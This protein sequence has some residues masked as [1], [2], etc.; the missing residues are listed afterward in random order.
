MT[1]D[2]FEQW[3]QNAADKARG[4]GKDPSDHTTGAAIKNKTHIIDFL[5]GGKAKFTL[6]SMKTGRSISY[7]TKQMPHYTAIFTSDK[8]IYCGAITKVLGDQI[9]FKP[10]EQYNTLAG[11]A[12]AWFC[13]H[14]T[15]YDRIQIWHHGECSMC[16]RALTDPK[17]IERGIGPV[18][19]EV[20]SRGELPF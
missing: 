8:N 3:E 5:F 2:S 10:T 20:L 7:H 1:P 4:F 17:S 15:E 13:R 18:C 11:D 14:F 12:F 19:Y 6:K 16:G 9:R